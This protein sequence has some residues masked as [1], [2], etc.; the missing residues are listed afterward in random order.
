M[1]DNEEEAPDRILIRFPQLSGDMNGVNATAHF[2]WGEEFPLG[3]TWRPA[4]GVLTCTL[5]HPTDSPMEAGRFFTIKA[6]PF[7]IDSRGVFQDTDSGI[8]F[9]LE[10]L[11]G[12]I[13][14]SNLTRVQPVG[15]FATRPS[16][17]FEPGRGMEE[18]ANVSLRYQL[19]ADWYRFDP[20]QQQTYKRERDSA[21]NA[22]VIV[23]AA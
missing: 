12:Y 2:S 1:T 7:V 9:E 10:S 15:P 21:L 8:S 18:P 4:G 11:E 22:A 19:N 16:L 14:I 23:I 5:L 13:P 20:A 6:G 3:T 17:R